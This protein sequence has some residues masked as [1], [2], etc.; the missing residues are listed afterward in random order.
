MCLFLLGLTK[1]QFIKIFREN[2]TKSIDICANGVPLKLFHGDNI[3]ISGF[4]ADSSFEA[5]YER[6]VIELK[7]NTSTRTFTSRGYVCA[8][9]TLD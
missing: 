9:K 8:K 3:Q 4:L 6:H 5:L 1:R 7:H 2:S